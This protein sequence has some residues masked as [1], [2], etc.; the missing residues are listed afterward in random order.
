M[1]QISV[2]INDPFKKPKD[3]FNIKDLNNFIFKNLV[4]TESST[5]VREIN[6]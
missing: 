2:L 1:K 3:K 5:G 4:K 6:I